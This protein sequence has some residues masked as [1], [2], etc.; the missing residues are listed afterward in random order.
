MI[1]L[2][3]SFLSKLRQRKRS[4][5]VHLLLHIILN[6]NKELRKSKIANS[7]ESI[8]KDFVKRQKSVSFQ[9][10]DSS[11]DAVN[12]RNSSEERKKLLP[13]W[14]HRDNLS[15]FT[16]YR[17]L[18]PHIVN[19]LINVMREKRQKKQDDERFRKFRFTPEN[20]SSRI[21]PIPEM[22]TS[23][24]KRKMSKIKEKS[25]GYTYLKSDRV[26]PKKNVIGNLKVIYNHNLKN[27]KSNSLSSRKVDSP[28]KITLRIHN[29]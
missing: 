3:R 5:I 13:I 18:P 26:K 23:E 28:T 19:E 12:S 17:K 1:L 25:M 11:P 8:L 10:D 24:P 14:E 27:K 6:Q 16:G 20:S 15:S 7:Q 21:S 22:F 2:R 29:P 9:D 4:K